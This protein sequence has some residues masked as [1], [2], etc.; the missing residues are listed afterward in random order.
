MQ[1]MWSLETF[2]PSSAAGSQSKVTEKQPHS[3]GQHTH[4]HTHIWKKFWPK[5]ANKF[6]NTDLSTETEK[7]GSV[8]ERK[9]KA[10]S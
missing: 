5:A 10:Y 3:K 9:R 1:I 7:A 2:A 8:G 4:K 6:G